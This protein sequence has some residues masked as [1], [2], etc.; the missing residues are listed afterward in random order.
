MLPSLCLDT[1]M[2][3]WL[4]LDTR[5][6][7]WLLPMELPWLQLGIKNDAVAGH[8]GGSLVVLVVV[9]VMGM[10]GVVVLMPMIRV[11]V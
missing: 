6:L 5:I 2:L 10:I 11:V 3:P 7:P 4:C 8:E 1:R 9:E